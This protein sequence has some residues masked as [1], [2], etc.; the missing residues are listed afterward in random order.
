MARSLMILAWLMVMAWPAEAHA[1]QVPVPPLAGHL[2]DE[3]GM[4]TPDEAATL[5]RT[6][7]SYEAATGG[8][9]VV[10]IVKSTAP[11]TIDQFSIRVADA[12]QPGRKGAD[13]GVLIT[14]ARDN[15]AALRRMRIEAGGGVQGALTDLQ[16]HRILDEVMAP[17]FREQQFKQGLAAGIDAIVTVLHP[18]IVRTR[19][20]EPA[21]AAIA[22]P[23]AAPQEA[24][25]DG[26][27]IGKVLLGIVFL[28][29]GLAWSAAF[30]KKGRARLN[31]GRWPE[32][33]LLLVLL[34]LVS[35]D[36]KTRGRRSN[37]KKKR[38][39]GGFD[40]GGSSGSW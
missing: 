18:H 4:L 13:D 23:A 34:V 26:F 15:D 39:G 25:A 16:A 9:I 31:D 40:G 7:A 20:G 37:E 33:Y 24:D 32:A 30:T 17:L 35:G 29:I 8:Q 27:P 14:V 1:W 10:L 28:H 19:A 11:E 3:A 5:E 6:L 36:G 22:H 38:D 12:W 2:V 21:P